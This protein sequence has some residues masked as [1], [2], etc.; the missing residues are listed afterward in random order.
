MLL[1]LFHSST[2]FF[3]FFVNLFGANFFLFF[4]ELYA[5]LLFNVCCVCC[6][7]FSFFF[8][9][10]HNYK[11]AHVR[12]CWFPL[13]LPFWHTRTFLFN[14]IFFF[15]FGYSA[16]EFW[17]LLNFVFSF[18]FFNQ[19]STWLEWRQFRWFPLAAVTVCVCV[20]LCGW[21][22]VVVYVCACLK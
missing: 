13:L 4:S 19:I 20:L 2:S 15:I 22:R 12:A 3:H 17:N 7:F 8:L 10:L 1:S 5:S 6:C 21:V 9:F 14:C 11:C 16:I 18:L